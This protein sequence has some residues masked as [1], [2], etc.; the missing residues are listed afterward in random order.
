LS[1]TLSRDDNYNLA[2]LC[3]ELLESDAAYFEAGAKLEALSGAMLAWMEEF[4]SL[5][6]GAVIP[7]VERDLGGLSPDVWL[8][9]V[10]EAVRRVGGRATR[11]YLTVSHPELEAVLRQRGYRAGT[12]LGFLGLRETEAPPRP[13]RISL[14][15]VED[16]RDWAAKSRV[17]DSWNRAAD[18]HPASGE[19]WNA[20]ERRKVEAG[21][22]QPY[23]ILEGSAVC[24]TVA[25]AQRSGLDRAKNLVLSSDCTGR[26][27]G[28]EAIMALSEGAAR[29][30][31][32]LGA[33]A[34]SGGTGEAMYRNLGFTCV[35]NQT[36]WFRRNGER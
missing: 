15:P 35:T 23:L 31:G 3:D 25:V 26:G 18:G 20:M 1:F 13:L 33:F 22:M 21:Y 6:V 27:I 7:R 10:E 36:E 32:L 29:N 8:S 12:E 9:H 2:K 14:R 16:E 30:G 24:G 19:A 4:P 11:L 28:R 34:I 17:H 5:S